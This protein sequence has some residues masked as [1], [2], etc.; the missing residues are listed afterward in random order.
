MVMFGVAGV[1]Y[2]GCQF[3][4]AMGLWCGLWAWKKLSIAVGSLGTGVGCG[5]LELEL[6]RCGL[7]PYVLDAAR[8]AL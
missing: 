1:D 5:E 3:D 6:E 8:G 4:G 2:C 7:L